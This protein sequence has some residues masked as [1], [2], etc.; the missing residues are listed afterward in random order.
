MAWTAP[1]TAID[2]AA[3]TAAQFNT[4]VRDNLLETAPAKITGHGQVPVT[5]GANSIVARTPVGD[6]ETSLRTV[7]ATSY[8]T[9][10]A[11]ASV[12]AT[13]GSSAY[14][15]LGGGVRVSTDPGSGYLSF[16]VTGAST[17]SGDDSRAI[18]LGNTGTAQVTHKSSKVFFLTGLTPG[19]NTFTTVHR[20]TNMASDVITES[21]RLSI[22]PL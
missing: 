18:S 14:V 19:E 20:K 9:G 15:I 21:R 13:T 6:L 8:Q 17:I 7:L 2:N 16:R 22:L 4:H 11:P 10:T 3:F 1:M 12:T 5:G